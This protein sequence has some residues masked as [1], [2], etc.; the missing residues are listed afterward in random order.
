MEL[1]ALIA[2]SGRG[3]SYV[4]D[5]SSVLALSQ[6]NHRP[7]N[8]CSVKQQGGICRGGGDVMVTEFRGMALNGVVCADVLWQLDI[9][10]FNEYLQIPPCMAGVSCCQ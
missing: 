6:S 8:T 9:V 2:L 5:G 3:F 10:P 4:T 1:S 7:S